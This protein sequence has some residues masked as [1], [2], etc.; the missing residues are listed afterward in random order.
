M[1]GREIAND[2]RRLD[3]RQGRVTK[4]GGVARNNEVQAR[5]LG[6]GDLHVILEVGTAW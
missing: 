6:A 2:I 5:E 1:C 4:T 3:G